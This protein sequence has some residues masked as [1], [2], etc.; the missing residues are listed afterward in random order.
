MRK[1][2]CTELPK[3][4]DQKAPFPGPIELMYLDV[5]SLFRQGFKH[6]VETR[7]NR[8]LAACLLTPLQYHVSVI[9]VCENANI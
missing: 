1:T 3:K 5:Y 8:T 6:T 9:R 2:Y 7:I 4:G